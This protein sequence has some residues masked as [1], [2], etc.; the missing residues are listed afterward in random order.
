MPSNRGNAQNNSIVLLEVCLFVC[1]VFSIKSFSRS[2][3]YI[4]S[5]FVFIR[6]LWVKMCVCMRLLYFFPYS[7]EKEKKVCICVG[8]NVGKIW[9]ELGR[10]L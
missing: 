8:V 1:L 2:F 10:E 9:A 4:V 7:N 5:D 3:A 6:F